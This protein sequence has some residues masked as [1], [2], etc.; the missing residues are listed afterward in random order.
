MNLSVVNKSAGRLN[1]RQRDALAQS[2]TIADESLREIR[3][4]SYLLHPPELDELGLKYALSRYVAEFMQ[5]STGGYRDIA[6][7]WPFATA[8]GNNDLSR[9]SGMFD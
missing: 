8:C 5:R 3:T 4:V 1:K 7:P 6:G 2:V 9:P